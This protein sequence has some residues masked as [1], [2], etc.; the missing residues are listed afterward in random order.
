MKFNQ[1]FTEISLTRLH[2]FLLA[3]LTLMEYWQ[4]LLAFGI[5]GILLYFLA[6]RKNPP[7]TEKKIRNDDRIEVPVAKVNDMKNGEYKITVTILIF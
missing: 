1:V 4:Y 7:K 2:R 6:L 3:D 5:G